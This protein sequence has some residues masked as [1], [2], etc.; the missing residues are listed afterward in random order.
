MESTE[1]YGDTEGEVKNYFADGALKSVHNYL[2]N[3]LNG[4]FAEYSAKGKVVKEGNYV[5]DLLH[6][7]VKHYT[8]DGKLSAV[9]I[10]YYGQLLDVR[11]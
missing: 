4:K 11:K 9:H 3:E 5:N 2:H 8:E 6:G 1:S 10:Y 7:A